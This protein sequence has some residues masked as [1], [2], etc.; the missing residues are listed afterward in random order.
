MLKEMDSW[1]NKE[2]P[3][4][5]GCMVCR[6]KRKTGQLDFL[7]IERHQFA[8]SDGITINKRMFYDYEFIWKENPNWEILWKYEGDSK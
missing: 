8:V 4:Y 2:T 7:L 3:G 1:L 5:G 6:V